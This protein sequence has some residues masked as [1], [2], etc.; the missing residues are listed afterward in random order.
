MMKYLIAIVILLSLGV[1]YLLVNYYIMRNVTM[2][3]YSVLS[4]DHN[5]EI[6]QYPA[7]ITAQVAVSA[8]R[9]D[10]V[11]EGFR[12]L[13]DFIFGNN[14]SATSHS[15]KVAMT[16]PVLQ[17][18]NEKIAMTAP[19]MQTPNEKI[20]MTAPVLQANQDPG[21]WIIKFIMPEQ[22]SLDTLPKPNNPNI[23]IQHEPARKV[24]TI[25]FSGRSTDALL[26]RNLAELQAYIKGHKLQA[27]G[28]YEYAFYNPPWTLPILRRNEILIEVE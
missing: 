24:I 14:V 28:A 6:R 19:V 18:P 2:P 21:K 26:G 4:K 25:R 17:A 12:Q 23:V 7:M 13:A 9:S 15:E 3:Q 8:S 5:I 22:Y 11:K 16:A 27:K 20:A 1:V 10:A